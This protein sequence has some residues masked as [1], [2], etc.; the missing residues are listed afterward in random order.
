[1]SQLEAIPSSP[2]VSSQE[3]RNPHLTTASFQVAVVE[4]SK[5]APE[6]PLFWMEQSQLHQLIHIRLVCQTS[7]Q[8]HCPSLDILNVFLVVCG[9]QRAALFCV[10]NS[11]LYQVS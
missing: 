6:P 8:L 1:M 2:L 4:N 11:F 3:V 5:V 7:H 9:Y 10:L